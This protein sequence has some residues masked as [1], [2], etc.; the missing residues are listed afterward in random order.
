MKGGKMDDIEI[1]DLFWKRDEKS[2]EE[3]KNKYNSYLYVIANNILKNKQDTDECLNDSYL[4]TWNS[5]PPHKPSKFKAF[6]SKIT[7]QRAI[8][9][10]RA[11]N[12]EKRKVINP[13]PSDEL[14]DIISENS[15]VWEELEYKR[16]IKSIN[17]FLFIETPLN[18]HIFICRYFFL[19]SI[20]DISRFYGLSESGVKNRLFQIRTRL[21]QY[22]EKED[23]DL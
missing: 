22:L 19:D 9:I 8:N 2:I 14:T 16:L 7:R 15:G 1:V 3:T 20:K 10:F 6:I 13:L 17:D 11:K 23:F 5:I 12:S 4:R 18:R 21:K